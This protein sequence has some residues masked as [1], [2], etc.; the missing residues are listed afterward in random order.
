MASPNT[1]DDS[2]RGANSTT[3]WGY[4]HYVPLLVPIILFL[5]SLYIPPMINADSSAGLLVLRSMLEGGAFNTFTSPDPADIANDVV[6]FLTLWSPGQY[7]V[8]G[9]FIWL[10][11]DYGLALSLTALISTLI[12]VLGWSQI[13]RS[14]TVSSFVLFVFMLG[15]TTFAYVTLPF[16]IYN[17]GE[18][19]LFAA[20]PWSLYA[21][22]W[23]AN[24]PPFLCLAVSLLSAALLFL[25]KLTGLIVFAANV[26]AISLVALVSQRRLSSSIISM[27]VAS[28]IA[29]LCFVM[30]WLARGPVAARGGTF[31]FSWLPIWFSL[32]G[33]AFSGTSA[34]E[35]LI[36]F[37]EHTV[38]IVS[39]STE[40]T[41]LYTRILR[42]SHVLGPLGVL[43]IMW[44]WLR[45]RQTRYRD[46][47][48]LLLTVILLYAIPLVAMY[49]RG[50]PVSAEDRHFRYAGILF[51]LLL[52]TAID[53]WRVP[54]AKGLACMVVIMLGLYGLKTSA[55]SAY[56]QMRSAG[57]YDPMYGIYQDIVS[58]ATLE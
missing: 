53:Q 51:F 29:A 26:G 6:T 45:L 43:L 33:V 9:S 42:V 20:A 52:L 28:A 31:T 41:D 22:R 14:F 46:M 5:S 4:G 12:G 36:W 17:G 55:M 8:P 1:L 18:V 44:V 47:T 32:T 37:L 2:K 38:R 34:L 48:V 10:G 23:A 27:W 16:R 30:F 21:M 13:A 15:L 49:I 24:K 25:T 19:L 3:S 57:Y 56:A 58:P 39:A 11:T 7:L 50:A 54:F 40:S 35:F